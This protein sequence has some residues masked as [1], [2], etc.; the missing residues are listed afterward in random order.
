MQQLRH[1]ISAT[2][3][4]SAVVRTRHFVRA[5]TLQFVP[6]FEFP[7]KLGP[8]HS[9]EMSSAQFAVEKL[10]RVFSVKEAEV[11]SIIARAQQRAT[12]TGDLDVSLADFAETILSLESSS[13]GDQVTKIESDRAQGNASVKALQQKLSRVMKHVRDKCQSM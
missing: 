3:G 6:R 13:P 4:C 12:A 1:V 8:Q 7:A 10:Q 2:C 9:A 11:E 5:F